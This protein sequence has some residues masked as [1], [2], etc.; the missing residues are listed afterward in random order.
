VHRVDGRLVAGTFAKLVLRPVEVP[1]QLGGR[2][3]SFQAAV[4]VQDGDAAEVHFRQY[5]DRRR[6]DLT[7]RLI[8]VTRFERLRQPPGRL[9]YSFR[10]HS[11]PVPDFPLPNHRLYAVS[12]DS[13]NCR[14]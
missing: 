3:S 14:R 11:I 7:Q 13:P 1:E 9:H 2:R 12:A 5:F 4:G 10:L 6:C 8:Q